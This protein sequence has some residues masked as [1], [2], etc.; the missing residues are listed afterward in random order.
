MNIQFGNFIEVLMTLLIE[1]D[2]RYEIVY[3]YNGK[4]SNSFELSSKNEALIDNY[5]TRCQTEENINID[6]EFPKLLSCI[7]SNKDD[8]TNKF[9]HD[10]DLLF[11]NTETGKSYYLE[12]KYNDDHDT[13]KFVDINRKFIKTYAYLVKELN[14]TDRSNLIPILFFFINNK[15]KDN[16]YIPENSNI[17][18][19]KNF[20]EK[21]LKVKY[22]DVDRHLLG[23]S[24]SPETMRT[25]KNLYEKT[26]N[27]Y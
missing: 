20:F 25:F 15:M 7:V 12:C 17:Y 2:G 23:L 6:I 26:M 19:G 8:R 16:I 21:F 27:I 3:N 24:E 10:I 5:I 13:G 22:E 9:K 4:K 18:R 11:K 1:D 14:I